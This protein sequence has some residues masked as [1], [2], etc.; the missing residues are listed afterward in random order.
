MDLE[1]LLDLPQCPTLVN[2]YEVF[3]NSRVGCNLAAKLQA[4]ADRAC[5]TC[6]VDEGGFR[7]NFS[8][9]CFE[10]IRYFGV[11]SIWVIHPAIEYRGGAIGK[12]N[13]C[14][15]NSILFRLDKSSDQNY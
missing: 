12:S 1:V 5:R 13:K 7:K 11:I 2:K 10:I 9:R 15:H 3:E 4:T 6:P 8:G 14:F